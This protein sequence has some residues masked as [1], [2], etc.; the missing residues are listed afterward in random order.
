MGTDLAIIDKRRTRPN[1]AEVMNIIGN[2]KDCDCI[3]VDDIVD[4][5]GTLCQA[6]NALIKAGAKSVA[7]YCVHPVLSGNAISNIENSALKE[8]I[9]T[10]TIALSEKTKSCKKIRQLSLSQLIAETII[11]VSNKLSV[12]SMFDD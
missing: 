8:V 3:I 10:D 1:E 4:T 5:A 6:S 7:A 9:V 12:S 11:R 2:V